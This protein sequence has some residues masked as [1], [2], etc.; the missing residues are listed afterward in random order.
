MK[1]A[2]LGLVNEIPRIGR[3]LRKFWPCL[4]VR[5]FAENVSSAYLKDVLS[6]N[7]ILGATPVLIEAGNSAGC[8]EDVTAGR[9][10]R[11]RVTRPHTSSRESIAPRCTSISTRA[12]ASDGWIP[13][14]AALARQRTDLCP[15]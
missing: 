5:K 1:G 7:K 6:V 15:R 9:I 14:R 11:S 10:G 12:L 4:S 8:D 2:H 3:L 13:V